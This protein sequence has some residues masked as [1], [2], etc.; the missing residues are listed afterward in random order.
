MN[1]QTKFTGTAALALLALDAITAW[2]SA[3]GKFPQTRFFPAS[4]ALYF[5]AAYRT[6]KYA[7]IWGTLS[8]GAFLGLVDATIG[9]KIC[10]WLGGDPQ[11]LYTNM[12]RGKWGTIVFLVMLFGTV[13]AL[14]AFLVAAVRNK[15]LKI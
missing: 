7:N 15:N 6:T 14:I 3:I 10:G 1:T 13:M 9:W 5:W 4:I 8:F 11:G 12:T 2:M